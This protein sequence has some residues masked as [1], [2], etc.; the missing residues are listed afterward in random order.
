MDFRGSQVRRPR[1]IVVAGPLEPFADGVRQ[2][3]AGQGMPWIRSL[4]TC[5]CWLI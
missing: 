5:I 1:R 3:L 2:D 4:T